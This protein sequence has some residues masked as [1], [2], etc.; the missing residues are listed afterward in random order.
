MYDS[1]TILKSIYYISVSKP[2]SMERQWPP[3]QET[4]PLFHSLWSHL[5]PCHINEA[6]LCKYKHV[7]VRM[8]SN[9]WL[10]LIKMDDFT[11]DCLA[12]LSSCPS[13]SLSS[14]ESSLPSSL[15]LQSRK[16]KYNPSREKSFPWLQY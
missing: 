8:R 3:E 6:R 16:R 9:V 2:P 5:A 12:E 11:T 4:G 14:S 13:S 15:S 10:K 1:I 7:L